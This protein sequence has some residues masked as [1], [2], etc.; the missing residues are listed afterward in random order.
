MQD[1]T[2][3][4][5]WLA[6]VVNLLN[7]MASEGITMGDCADPAELM[8][9]IAEHLGFGDHEDPWASVTV[10]LNGEAAHA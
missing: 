7:E 5:G 6:R 8:V 4:P 3:P 9:E 1:R 10:W 2:L